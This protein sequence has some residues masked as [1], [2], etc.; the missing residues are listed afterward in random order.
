MIIYYKCML[1][2]KNLKKNMCK[3]KF[4]II[5]LIELLKMDFKSH[6]IE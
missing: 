1:L 2:K 6:H 3:I 4:K 5:K